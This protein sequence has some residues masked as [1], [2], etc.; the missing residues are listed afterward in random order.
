MSVKGRAGSLQQTVG[1]SV[2]HKF[3][4]AE[5]MRRGILEMCQEMKLG[6]DELSQRLITQ[7][8]FLGK[9]KVNRFPI[10]STK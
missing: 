5:I 2:G 4:N 1:E 6:G 3:I 10:L 7:E 9:K 8:G